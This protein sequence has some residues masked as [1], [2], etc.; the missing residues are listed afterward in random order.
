MSRGRERDIRKADNRKRV[1]FCTRCISNADMK[2]YKSGTTSSSRSAAWRNRANWSIRLLDVSRRAVL[3]ARF[4]R[5]IRAGSR[6][7]VSAKAYIY[8]SD[9]PGGVFISQ[10]VIARQLGRVRSPSV[11]LAVSLSR[12]RS[13]EIAWIVT[14]TWNLPDFVYGCPISGAI[15]FPRVFF[16]GVDAGDYGTARCCR[17]EF[18]AE[19]FVTKFINDNT[20]IHVAVFS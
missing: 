9:T 12:S 17:L 11:W 13:R 8:A 2:K 3:R 5:E 20:F 14:F 6:M 15:D 16:R 4:S 7:S 18:P 1:T 19:S 10:R